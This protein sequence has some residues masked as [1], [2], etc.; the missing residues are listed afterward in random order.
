MARTKTFDKQKVVHQAL[1]LFWQQGYEAT[2]IDDL[3]QHLGLNRSSIY[4]T[5]GSKHAL[6]IMA[7]RL[8]QAQVVGRIQLAVE[9][10]DIHCRCVCQHLRPDHRDACTG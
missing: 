10:A 1:L 5:F 7:L 8:Y 3:E 2:S 9:Q 6:F 4:N